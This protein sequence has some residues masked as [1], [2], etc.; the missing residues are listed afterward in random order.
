MVKIR[1][2]T[3]EEIERMLKGMSE[4]AKKKLLEDILKQEGSK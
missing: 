4:E 3:D 2:F 1:R